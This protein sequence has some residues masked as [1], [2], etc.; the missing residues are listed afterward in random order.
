MEENKRNIK[1]KNF[2][3]T[4]TI[5]DNKIKGGQLKVIVEAFALQER[6][7]ETLI[8][9][10]GGFYEW[11][12]NFLLISIGAVI[13]VIAKLG[14]FLVEFTSAKDKNDVTWGIE[15][16]E[17]YSVGI[18]FVLFVLLL[19]A[20]LIFKNRKDKLVTKIR[21]FFKSARNV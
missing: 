3:Q 21:E 8:S 5:D 11:S 20:G 14:A 2:D 10:G 16:Y 7:F 18:A 17:W 6:D 4:L 12:K 13:V 15:K 9:P 1:N 19:A